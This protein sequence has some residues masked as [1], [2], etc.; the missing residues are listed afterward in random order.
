MTEEVN[1]DTFFTQ[2]ELEREKNLLPLTDHE[3]EVLD[4]LANRI[5]DRFE[6][7]I[8]NGELHLGK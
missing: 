3:Q 6:E 5:I 7:D 1:L 8:A 4:M 2:E